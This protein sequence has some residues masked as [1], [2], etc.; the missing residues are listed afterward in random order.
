VTRICCQQLE[1]RVGEPEHNRELSIS[2]I[3][4]AAAGGAQ[5][6]VRPELTT[7]GYMFRSRAE[8]HAAAIA[9]DGP[10]IAEWCALAARHGLVIAAGFCE[11]GAPYNSAA[12]IDPTG[13]RAVYRKLQLWDRERLWFD[14]GDALPPVINTPVGRVSLLICYDLEFPELTRTVALAGAELLLVPTNWPLMDTPAGERP[15]E[16]TIAMATARINHMAIA[17]ADR[18]GV[19]RGQA[20]TAG[21]AIIDADGWVAGENRRP[22]PL[23]AEVDLARARDKRFTDLADSFADR[24]PELYGAVTDTPRT[25]DR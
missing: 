5:V 1:P 12:L 17:C 9:A 23:Y 11:R 13:L 2:A 21:T 8:A 25:P 6:V 3:E 19:E 15:G 14:P 18:A 20:W 22:G 24:R 7:S 16:V 4:Q 10:L